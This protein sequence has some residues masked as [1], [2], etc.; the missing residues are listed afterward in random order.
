[1]LHEIGGIERS[2]PFPFLHG[3]GSDIVAHIDVP[4]KYRKVYPD[5]YPIIIGDPITVED[6][7][8]EALFVLGYL[9]SFLDISW[10]SPNEWVY[11]K[12]WTQLELNLTC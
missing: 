6:V 10:L 5:G 7:T 4:A 12:P 8:W 2:M 1:M 3:L 9:P 11:F